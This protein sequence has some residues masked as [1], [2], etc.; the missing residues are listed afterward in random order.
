LKTVC[1]VCRGT[2]LDNFAFS[3]GMGMLFL[4]FVLYLWLY[5][6]QVSTA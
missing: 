1:N 5:L 3:D 4:D 2:S 6:D